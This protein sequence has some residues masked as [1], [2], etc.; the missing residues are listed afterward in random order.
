MSASASHQSASTIEA[1]PAGA[2]AA[3]VD[4]PADREAFGIFRLVTT[5]ITLI[6]G[7][8]VF[9]LAGDEAANGASGAAIL[10]AW[11]I[12]AVGVLC[13]VHDVLRALARQA[14]AQGRHLQLRERRVR[15]LPRAST[16]RGGYW[17]SALLCTVSFSALLFGALSR[18]SS[19]SSAEG[20]EPA[21]H[22]R[23][24]HASSGSTCSSSRAASRR[25]TGVN[26][27]ITIS[28]VV[29]IFVA[30]T[31]IVFLQKFDPGHLHGEL[32]HGR[33]PR[34]LPFLRAGERHHDGD[35]LGV[36]RHRGRGGHLPGRAKNE[37]DV[38]KATII[39]F[40]CVLTDLPAGRACFRRGRHAAVRIWPSWRI[41]A[42]A[43]VMEAR[44]GAVGRRPHQRRRGAVRFVGAMLGYTVLIERVAVRG[45]RAG[46]VHQGVRQDEQEGRTHRHACGHEHHR[47]GLPTSSCCSPTA[48]TSS[49]TRISAGM[50]LAAVPAVRRVLRQAH[51]H[52]NRDAFKGKLGGSLVFVAHLRHRRRTSTAS[53][54]RARA[55]A[56]GLTLM[57]L[58]VRAGHPHVHQGEEGAGR[59]VPARL[60]W[61]RWWCSSSWPPPWHRSSW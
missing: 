44:R 40:V 58:S 25:S 54:S 15:R 2:P 33:R 28:K 8:G 4:T 36:R 23:G 13:L 31:A 46:R 21:V 9:S 12:S 43:G 56:V 14:A 42:L 26:A 1:A 29:P 61:T 35:H 37:R 39:A 47:R 51:V 45:G 32:R 50:I 52:A 3:S 59:A 41:P 22:H 27:V 24:E 19:P 48:P 16:A 38:G 17:I 49:S 55:G 11:G 20:H 57:S 30:I 53:S 5:V 6:L 10:T 7:G 34:S 60:R 18:T